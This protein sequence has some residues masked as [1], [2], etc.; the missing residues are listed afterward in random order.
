MARSVER[1]KSGY[2]SRETERW[3]YQWRDREVD[4]SVERQRG[5][6]FQHRNREVARLVERQRGG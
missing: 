5:S 6:S 4:R 2:I 1:Q 3:L